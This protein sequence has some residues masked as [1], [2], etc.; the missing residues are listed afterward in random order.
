VIRYEKYIMLDNI[1]SLVDI[2][3]CLINVLAMCW[4]NMNLFNLYCT[5]NELLRYSWMTK[6][7][8]S[9]MSDIYL[10]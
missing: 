10:Y 8:E 4:G 2:L 6:Y 9:K 3:L 1:A 7:N 5:L